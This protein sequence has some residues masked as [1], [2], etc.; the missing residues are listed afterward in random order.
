MRTN[1][2]VVSAIAIVLLTFALCAIVR[3]KVL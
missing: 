1:V 2:P 3:L